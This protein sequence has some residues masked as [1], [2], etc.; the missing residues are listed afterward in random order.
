MTQLT[1]VFGQQEKALQK[2]LDYLF[3]KMKKVPH[4]GAVDELTIEVGVLKKA[5]SDERQVCDVPQSW[6]RLSLHLALHCAQVSRRSSSNLWFV[7]GA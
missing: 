2:Q 5:L 3:S 6:Q 4:M 7:H 1:P